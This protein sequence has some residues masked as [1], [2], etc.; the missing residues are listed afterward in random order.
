MCIMHVCQVHAKRRFVLQHSSHALGCRQ[1]L[2]WT[3]TRQL[4]AG[5]SCKKRV[6]SMRAPLLCKVWFLHSRRATPFFSFW[7]KQWARRDGEE[8]SDS[9]LQLALENYCH[10]RA[11][12]FFI[13][14]KA[15]VMPKSRSRLCWLSFEKVD[16]SNR[17][18]VHQGLNTHTYAESVA[19]SSVLRLAWKEKAKK[20]VADRPPQIKI[21]RK[22]WHERRPERVSLAFRKCTLI[23]WKLARLIKTAYRCCCAR[24]ERKW[25]PLGRVARR[26]P[27]TRD[28]VCEIG[29]H[30]KWGCKFDTGNFHKKIIIF[31][32]CWEMKY[33]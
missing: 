24:A 16:G 12:T 31:S 7:R 4:S 2:H 21:G 15:Y 28:G 9:L 5:A 25:L 14:K 6:L 20:S 26:T 29:T 10:R 27:H 33:H 30:S 13:S 8:F 18:C 11:V 17:F 22:V 32:V 19:E 1:L 23:K 3:E